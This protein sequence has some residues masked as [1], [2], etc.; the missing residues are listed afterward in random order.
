MCR[1][2]TCSFSGLETRQQCACL[3]DTTL[4]VGAGYLW[5]RAMGGVHDLCVNNVDKL[6]A[7]VAGCT[8]CVPF[9]V[10]ARTSTAVFCLLWRVA[11]RVFLSVVER[12]MH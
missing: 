12:T 6:F 10:L 1:A 3:I 4:S 11:M 7:F 2:E 8:R 5:V 9:A